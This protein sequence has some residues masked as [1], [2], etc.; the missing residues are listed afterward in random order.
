MAAP[1]GSVLNT[2][3]N[4]DK[5]QEKAIITFSQKARNLL[6]N[7]YSLRFQLE[8]IDRY[9]MR[10]MDFT[11]ANI[12]AR[13]ANRAGDARKMRDVTV[14][15]VMPQVEAALGYFTNVFLT[16]YP[17]FGVSSDP[18]FEDQALQMETIIAE[19]AITAG[20]RRQLM[21]FFRDGL[22]YNLHGMEL[23]WG[24]Q[25]VSKIENSETEP[26][27]ASVKNILWAGNK[28]RRMDLYNTFF[29]P[30]VHPA[31]IHKYGEFAGYI[32]MYSRVQM[33]QY[34]NDNFGKINADRVVRALESSPPG[35][36]STTTT[37]GAPFAYYVPI[38][39]PT[40]IMDRTNLQTFDWLAWA[41][42][43]ANKP[44][45]I[46]YSNVYEI[47]KVYARII[48]DDFN[49]NVSERNTP[50]VW[51]FIIVNGQVVVY[52]ERQSNAHNFIPIFFGQPIEDGLDYQ[53]KSFAS[54][55]TDMQ[56]IA[57]AMWNGY[58]ASKRRLVGDRVLYDPLRVRKEDINS[59]NPAAK[60]PVRPTAFG[61]PVSEAVYQFPFRDEQ[62][63]TLLS[64]A[65]LVTRFAD[66]INGQNPA[67]QGQ[68]V[69]GNKTK[70]EYEDIMGHGNNT[71]QVMAICTDEQV[72]TDMKEAIKLNILQYQ[73]ETVL[74]NRDKQKNVTVNPVELRKAAVHFKV[75]DG[76]MPEDKQMS[77]DEFQTALQVLGSSPP[78]AAGYNMAPLFTYVMK[79]RGADLSP[80]EK[81]QLQVQFE[82]QQGQWAGIV[83]E[84]LKVIGKNADPSQLKQLLDVLQQ[85]LQLQ[86][87]MPQ[88]LQQ[89][90]QEKQQGGSAQPAAT[91][92]ALESTQGG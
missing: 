75:S 23:E 7:Q 32:Y 90:M 81:S 47:A 61:K 46:K 27:K 22:K 63:Q 79:L 2:P 84:A 15:I 26:G 69:K 1:K 64:G 42:N 3:Y 62:T 72:F 82:Q 8:E 25:T 20:W 13:Q 52:A 36:S 71:N 39:N 92:A 12:R 59:T 88:A 16:G 56:D 57:S 67:Q 14:P 31:E 49:L 37:S 54:N 60:I 55:V 50:Q 41:N 65:D 10:E 83:Q 24:Q 11:E 53:T 38:I 34:F 68:F 35:A 48:P 58:I 44:E 86:P 77:T 80:F 89:E 17:P 28:M 70:H 21:M 40:P 43:V 18:D 29:D 87:Q 73:G 4:L 78:L 51:K 76:I 66:K 45:H 91:S 9:Y 85:L 19:N 33:K 74:F 5:D 6:Q 30:R